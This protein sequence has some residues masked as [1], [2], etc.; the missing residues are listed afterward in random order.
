VTGDAIPGQEPAGTTQGA[1]HLSNEVGRVADR[2]RAFVG[3]HG[4]TGSAVVQYLGRP[5]YRIVVVAADGTFADA[6]VSDRERADAVCAAA[7]TEVADWSRDLT[8]RIT[9][10][11]GDRRR[12]AGT[13]R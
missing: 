2:F 8:S 11:A 6:V 1:E 9:I 7:G 3:A 10:S 5:G 12:M 4:G 13:G